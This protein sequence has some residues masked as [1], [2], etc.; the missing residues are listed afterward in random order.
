MTLGWLVVGCPHTVGFQEVPT[1]A[2]PDGTIPL[3]A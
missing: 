2:H 1:M 3:Q